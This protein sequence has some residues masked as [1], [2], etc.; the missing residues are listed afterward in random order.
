MPDPHVI[1]LRGRWEYAAETPG[2]TVRGNF[3]ASGD[4]LAGLPAFS[5]VRFSRRFHRPTGLSPGT[6]VRL[7]VSGTSA[8]T[9]V[10]LN[11]EVLPPAATG[12]VEIAALLQSSNQLELTLAGGSPAP[13]HMDVSLAIEEPA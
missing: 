6:R 3:D 1:R 7:V 4:W 5:V 12:P 2:G 13:L 9:Q 11:G 10:S 8:E